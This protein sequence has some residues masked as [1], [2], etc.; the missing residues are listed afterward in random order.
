MHF[1]TYTVNDGLAHNIINGILFDDNDNLWI[2]TN[3]GISFFDRNENKFYNFNSS[4][5]LQS[6]IFYKTACLKTSDGMMLFGG[7]NGFNAFYPSDIKISSPDLNT[8]I[9]GFDLFGRTVKAGDTIN[10]RAILNKPVYD[11][12][13][14]QLVSCQVKTDG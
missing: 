2:S 1:T 10:G 8:T 13:K 3:N 5:G 7:I 6:N 14:I 9:T 12:E 4:D 11:S